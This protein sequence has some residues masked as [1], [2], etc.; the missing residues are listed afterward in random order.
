[1]LLNDD[2][3]AENIGRG[4]GETEQK[5]EENGMHVRGR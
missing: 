5:A 1:M 4:R 3:A 2:G